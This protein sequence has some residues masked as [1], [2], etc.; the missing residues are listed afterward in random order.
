[1]KV[2]G[3]DIYVNH[4][5]LHLGA[6]DWVPLSLALADAPAASCD[7]HVAV[8]VRPQ[9]GLIKVRLFVQPQPEDPNGA[10][11]TF[12]TVFDGSLL[13]PDGRLAIGDV[14][15]LTRFV[16]RV[17]DRGEYRVRVDADSPGANARA[18]DITI[19]QSST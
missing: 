9:T 4:A 11:P 6:T 13:L 8:R 5:V 19:V 14:E 7:T 17:G 10:D 3:V 16:H 2:A 15:Q 12:V 1:M 18:I